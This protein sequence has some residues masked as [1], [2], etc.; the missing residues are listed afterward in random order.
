MRFRGD[1]VAHAHGDRLA[2]LLRPQKRHRDG[3]ERRRRAA[4]AAALAHLGAGLV[5]AGHHTLARGAGSP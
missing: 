3:P 1:S 5:R 2:G 4:W